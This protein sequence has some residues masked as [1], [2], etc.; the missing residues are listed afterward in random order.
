MA[1]PSG[2]LL[3]DKPAGWTSH[4][5]VA[6]I[7]GIA[8]TR[9]VGHAGTLDPMATGLLIL[10]I[11]SATKLLTF[12][13]GDSKTYL[14]T[15]RLGSTTIT[16]DAESEI[17]TQASQERL[18]QITPEK[19]HAEIAK[20]TGLISQVPSSVSAIKVNGERAYAKVRAGESVELKAREITIS[21]FALTKEIARG[22]NYVDL[23]VQVS[24]S[25]GTYIR[26]I[27]RDL[28][29][30]LNVGG[31]LRSLRR[32]RV[33]SYE[34]SDAVKMDGLKDLKVIPLAEAASKM[35][36]V[37]KLSE[38]E[39]TDLIHGKRLACSEDYS[40]KVAAISPDGLLVAIL[41]KIDKTLKSI[42]V[43]TGEKNG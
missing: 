40:D 38:A 30:A 43:F 39:V 27:A 41:E 28:G 10:G 32:V 8:G 22:E 1:T 16:D 35:F 12:I 11:G 15:I 24:C 7:R 19:I 26:A 34:V 9:R 20:L 14:G 23:E 42:V 36:P 37:K 3:V 21:E 5:V 4:D 13:V 29:Q 6:K 25:S 18:D 17:L 31:H 33:G 2:L